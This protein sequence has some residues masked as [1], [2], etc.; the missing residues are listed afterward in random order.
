MF[1][2]FPK[3]DFYFTKGEIKTSVYTGIFGQSS[4]QIEDVNLPDVEGYTAH[5]ILPNGREE[6]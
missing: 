3:D 6:L 4:V 5:R 2:E 1:D